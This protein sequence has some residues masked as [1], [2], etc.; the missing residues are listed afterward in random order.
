M[1]VLEILPDL[2]GRLLL[3]LVVAKV[4]DALQVLA[5]VDQISGHD[6]G[7]VVPFV[8]Q[9][10]K[11]LVP[12]KVFDLLHFQLG[13]ELLL[14]LPFVHLQLRLMLFCLHFNLFKN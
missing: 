1:L 14:A 12:Q 6:E 13:Q 9:V 10:F 4:A 11:V 5:E 2:L 8:L 7:N 3:A